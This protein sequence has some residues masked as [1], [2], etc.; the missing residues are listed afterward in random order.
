MAGAPGVDEAPAPVRGRHNRLRLGIHMRRHRARHH[1]LQRLRHG[2]RRR[3]PG[4]HEWHHPPPRRPQPRGMAV[5]Q[6][7]RHS[8]VAV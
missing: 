8:V 1:R 2:R 5:T 3:R 4:E 6:A 7:A